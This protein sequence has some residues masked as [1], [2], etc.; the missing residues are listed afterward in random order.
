MFQYESSSEDKVPPEFALLAAL[1][2]ST[3]ALGL[4][5]AYAPFEF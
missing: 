5:N 3:K 4:P 1:S 2:A